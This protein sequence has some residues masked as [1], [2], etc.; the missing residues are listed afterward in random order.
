M[1]KKN[2]ILLVLLW[3]FGAALNGF[4][5][6][7]VTEETVKAV[8]ANDFLNSIG[9]NSAIYRRGENLDKTIECCQYAGIRWI[10][11]DEVNPEQIKESHH[12]FFSN[13]YSTPVSASSV[14]L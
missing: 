11:M 8:P 3:A 1:M 5:A 6:F 2:K 12:S 10:R 7:A 4:S 13:P 14:A 9:A